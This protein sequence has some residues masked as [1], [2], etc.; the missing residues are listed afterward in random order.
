MKIS[1]GGGVGQSGGV[2]DG[3]EQVLPA[4][5]ALGAVA[6][7]AG[8]PMPGPNDPAKLLGVDMH[9]LARL[10]TLVADDLLPSLPRH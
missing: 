8:Y 7:V 9:Q 5:F 6:T 2:I 10:V 1:P 4:G 3:N